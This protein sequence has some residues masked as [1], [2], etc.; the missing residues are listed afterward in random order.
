V[1]VLPSSSAEWPV[2]RYAALLASAAIVA[3]WNV[4]PAPF[5]FDDGSTI[6]DNPYI[7]QLWPPSVSLSA[8]VQ[9]AVAGRPVV[10]LTLAINHALG[11]LEPWGYHAWNLATHV[12]TAWLLF[13][14]VRRTSGSP[15]VPDFLRTRATAIAFAISLVWLVHPLQTEIV[16]Y[17]T[18]R[19]E[20]TMGLFYLLTLY[21]AIRVMSDPGPDGRWT[22][23]A[24]AACALGMLSKESM[25]TAPVMVLVYDAVFVAG[26][27]RAAL[28]ARKTLY[29]GLAASWLLLAA[30]IAPGP[31]WRSAGFSSGVSPWTYLLHQPEMIVTYL[32]L[33]VWP[34]P[35]VLDY[36]RTTATTLTAAIPWAIPLLGLLVA[37]VIAWR[38]SAVLAFVAAWF[39]ITLAPSSSILPI[40]TEVGAER[41]MYL[42]LMAVFVLLVSG[43]VWLI[44]RYVSARLRGRTSTAV[45]LATCSI[46]GWL[47]IA[48]N[49]EYR[50]EIGIWETVLA[51][52]PGGR[53]HYNLGLAL[54]RAGRPDEAWT[55]LEEGAQ[56]EPRS[57]YALGLM[58][59]RQDRFDE[60]ARHYRR[61][62]ELMPDDVQAPDGYIRLGIVLLQQNELIDAQA[63]LEQALRMRPQNADARQAYGVTL[64]QLGRLED[65]TRELQR[66]VEL[67]PEDHE[68]HTQLG[69]VLIERER[70]TEA[71][72]SLERSVTL[73]PR[74]PQVR[75]ALGNAL[76]TVGRLPEA[77]VQFRA[78]VGIEPSSPS[79]H[80][81]LG[82]ALA[83]N[84][85]VAEGLAELERAFELGFDEPQTR[86][87]YETL[88]RRFGS[89]R[90]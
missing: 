31:R 63:A 34:A 8:P 21:S 67:A 3:F 44:D 85:Q 56:Q 42:P 54:D 36:G 47:T 33:A 87:G 75:L 10:S 82:T 14:I 5:V 25:V 57:Y 35:L 68:G 15:V 9:S 18:Q 69:L 39:W 41:R 1:A 83:S 43:A 88:K 58:R 32:K 66:Y 81:M 45:L 60:A 13:A 65:A 46:F 84:G 78:G 76:A 29:T 90:P 53:A 38:Q 12:V 22:A 59:E 20:A 4:L 11:G 51:R 64:M 73:A 37:S 70:H 23:V 48:R 77:I 50:S 80:A 71:I 62:L 24:V 61:Y 27:P 30:M 17:V 16:G 52:R 86:A 2:S 55:H 19:T 72:A 49:A 26:S 7:R 28:R 79:L 40:A 6:T 89:T 74:D